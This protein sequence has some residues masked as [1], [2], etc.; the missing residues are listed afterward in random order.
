MTNPTPAD[1]EELA[2][3][4]YEHDTQYLKSVDPWEKIWEE[5]KNQWRSQATAALAWMR[6]RQ[7]KMFP[8]QT[9]LKAKPHPL[10]IPWHIAELAYSV[11]A[12]NYGTGQSLQ[13]LAE[14]GGFSP[15]EMDMFLPD[16]REQCEQER[17]RSRTA[18]AT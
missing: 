5:N 9:D 12:A 8:I 4:L 16:W 1:V 11:Y 7:P 3:V 6:S 10:Q 13:R 17:M 2:R 15:G 18:T 14:R